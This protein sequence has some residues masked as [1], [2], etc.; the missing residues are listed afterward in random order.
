MKRFTHDQY[1]KMLKRL[2]ERVR[3]N[4]G[5]EKVKKQAAM[6]N[7]FRLLAAKAAQAG[8]GMSV[9]AEIGDKPIQGPSD[10]QMAGMRVLRSGAE[11]A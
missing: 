9:T 3:K 6:A 2:D 7:V 4:A 5:P 10:N 8:R 1:I 11:D